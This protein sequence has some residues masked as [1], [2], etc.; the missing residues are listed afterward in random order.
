MRAGTAPTRWREVP[1]DGRATRRLIE[2]RGET[3]KRGGNHYGADGCNGTRASGNGDASA[4]AGLVGMDGRAEAH[5]D[6]RV[7]P[8]A[9]RRGGPVEAKAQD[10]DPP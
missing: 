6:G 9:G 2:R 3:G 7:A 4:L 5:L 8:R 1:R 10:D